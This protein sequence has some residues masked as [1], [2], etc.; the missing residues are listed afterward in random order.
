[1]T[2]PTSPKAEAELL[3]CPCCG[4]KT[5][6]VNHGYR[7]QQQF[8]YVTCEDCDV[9]IGWEPLA[10]T[11]IRQWNTRYS[12]ASSSVSLSRWIPVSER[13][14]NE[15]ISVLAIG[16][17]LTRPKV[18]NFNN[19]KEGPLWSSTHP[20]RGFW[21]DGYYMTDDVTHWQPLPPPP[22]EQS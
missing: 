14:P 12:A 7:D 11:A 19:E 20:A 10:E 18:I 22:T 3:P 4:C 15:N 9:S 16:G 6:E 17:K 8:F 5:A 1:M 2:T 21:D 13:L